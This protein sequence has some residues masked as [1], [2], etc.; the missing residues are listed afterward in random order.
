MSTIKKNCLVTIMAAALVTMAASVV[1]AFAQDTGA[2]SG[3]TTKA[4]R[5]AQR[6]ADR[7]AAHAKNKAELQTLE[8][9]G[10]Q[11]NQ[12]GATY[13]SKLEDAQKKA[14]VGQ[15]ASQ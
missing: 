7:K 13:P 9:N 5:K 8:K 15:A 12:E 3:A 1:P 4:A 11:P 14:G 2:A 10:Y 6:K